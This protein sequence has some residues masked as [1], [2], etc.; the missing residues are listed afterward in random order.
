M[1]MD[2]GK[3]LKMAATVDKNKLKTESGIRDVIKD[4]ASRSG[5]DLSKR[6]LDNYTEQVKKFM[7]K[8]DVGSMLDQLKKK[9][10]DQ[11]DIDKIKK[12]MK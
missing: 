3:I 10:L 2:W 7:Q 9:G 8:K 11:S 12:G 6:D 5:K 1:I 4:L